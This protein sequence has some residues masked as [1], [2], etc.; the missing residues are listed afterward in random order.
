[1]TKRFWKD[2]SL[3]RGSEELAR[4]VP[5]GDLFWRVAY[6]GA[7]S[8]PNLKSEAAKLAEMATRHD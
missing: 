6:R 3:M 2:N 8:Q 1:M 4:L 5:H 7:V